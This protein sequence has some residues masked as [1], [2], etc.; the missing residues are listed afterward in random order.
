MVKNRHISEFTL[1]SRMAYFLL[2][3]M[4]YNTFRFSSIIKFLI[5]Q[6]FWT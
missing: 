5:Q 3:P 4:I 6:G 2:K 1:V